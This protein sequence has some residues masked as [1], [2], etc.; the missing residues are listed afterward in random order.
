MRQT[1]S[2]LIAA[3]AVVTA[4][5]VPALAC[6]GG[7]LLQSS[8]SPCGQAYVSPC[9]QPEVYVAPTPTFVETGCNSCGG[10]WAHERLPDPVQQYY[11]ANQG[12]TYTGPGNFAPYP[13]YQEGAVSGWSGY[14]HHSYRYGYEGYRTHPYFRPWR[15]H[16]GYGYPE[17]R[18]MRYGYAPHHYGYETRHYGYEPHRYGFE[19]HRGYTS[20]YSLPPR[21]FYPHHSLRYGY[22]A[23]YG[24][25]H[26]YGFREHTLRRYY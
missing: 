19:S 25:P 7:G 4:S 11:Y 14:R 21:E 5:A 26:H 2:G 8:C 22:S 23:P 24:M 20:H 3:F 15:E 1:I 9:A 6:G 12:P 16:T 13:T 10:G 17:R 18:S